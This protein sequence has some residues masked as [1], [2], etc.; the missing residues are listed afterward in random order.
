MPEPVSLTATLT[1]A[2]IAL[3]QSAILLRGSPSSK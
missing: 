2:P 3:A 1:I